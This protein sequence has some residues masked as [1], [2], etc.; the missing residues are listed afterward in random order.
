MNKNYAAVGP[1][2]QWAVAL[3]GVKTAGMGQSSRAGSWLRRS[4]VTVLNPLGAVVV[5]DEVINGGEDVPVAGL[6]NSEA[7]YLVV[8]QS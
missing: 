4:R 7:G 5:F 3:N 1:D 2:G 6:R 8:G